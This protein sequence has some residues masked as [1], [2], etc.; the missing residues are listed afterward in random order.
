[1]LL[2]VAPHGGESCLCEASVNLS[3]MAAVEHVSRLLHLRTQLAASVGIAADAVAVGSKRDRDADEAVTEAKALLS[4]LGIG[5]KNV[6][7]R[8]TLEQALVALRG[9]P[10][11]ELPSASA[12]AGFFFAGRWL[13]SDRSLSE[14]VGH[15]EKSKVKV[16]YGESSACG[17]GNGGGSSS[18]QGSSCGSG[19]GGSSSS[20]GGGGNLPVAATKATAPVPESSSGRDGAAGADEASGAREDALSLSAFFRARA[21]A[22]Q[23]R[24]AKDGGAEDADVADADEDMPVLNARQLGVLES[25]EEL[26]AAMRDPRLQQLLRH[27]DGAPTREGALRRLDATLKAD[28]DFEQFALATLRVIGYGPTAAEGGAGP[29]L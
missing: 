6:L 23:P 4:P 17:S 13:E 12:S 20:G 21:G 19:S 22:P 8:E 18:N 24:L 28:P 26:Q 15:N 11:A 25:S 10:A 9:S 1:M 16:T 29:S 5:R 3:V 7:T 14:Y 27:I 2:E